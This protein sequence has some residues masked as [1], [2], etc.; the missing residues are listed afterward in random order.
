M[1]QFAKVGDRVKYQSLDD[2]VPPSFGRVVEVSPDGKRGEVEWD[3]G[4]TYT[5]DFSDPA[6]CVYVVRE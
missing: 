5:Y 2:S 6:S 3:D 4:E 1:K